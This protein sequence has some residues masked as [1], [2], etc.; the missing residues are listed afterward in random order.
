MA[1]PGGAVGLH[2]VAPKRLADEVV[3]LKWRLSGSAST[4]TA[5]TANSSKHMNNVIL[6]LK[7][8]SIYMM[9][10]INKYN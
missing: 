4:S 5:A 9:L 2:H 6:H 8:T 7:Y 10:S 3:R 1:A